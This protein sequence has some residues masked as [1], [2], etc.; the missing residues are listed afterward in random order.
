MI[1]ELVIGL[2]SSYLS[3]QECQNYRSVNRLWDQSLGKLLIERINLGASFVTVLPKIRSYEQLQTWLER[4]KS[5]S[6][7]TVADFTGMSEMRN[8]DWSQLRNLCTGIRRLN[9]NTDVQPEQSMLSKKGLGQLG[10]FSQLRILD[11]SGNSQFFGEDV[12]PLLQA[13]TSL[14]KVNFLGLIYL[15]DE[16]LNGLAQQRELKEL[17]IAGCSTLSPNFL[18][19]LAKLPELR[20]LNIEECTQFER[21]CLENLRHT[22]LLERINFIGCWRL[23]VVNIA[24]L[25]P[26]KLL[27]T[28]AVLGQH[29]F[30]AVKL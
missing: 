9:L 6:K 2:V 24:L 23:G 14:E 26:T 7:L 21:T 27:Q 3:N 25:P 28:K 17:N 12:A 16:D 11:L 29:T 20:A 30:L 22:P 10:S 13:T 1:N 15:R 19:I 5:A 18:N 4:N 8:G